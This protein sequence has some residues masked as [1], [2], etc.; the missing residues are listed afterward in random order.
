[1]AYTFSIVDERHAAAAI[2]AAD[3]DDDEDYGNDTVITRKL[4]Q[5]YLPVLKP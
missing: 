2:A 5:L 3:D 4:L 1:M